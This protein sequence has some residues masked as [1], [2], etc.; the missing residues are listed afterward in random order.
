MKDFCIYLKILKKMSQN[1]TWEIPWWCLDLS[2]PVLLFELNEEKG[3]RE[4]EDKTY[5]L[6]WF[7]PRT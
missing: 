2:F 5:Q 1:F 6:S 7:K 3:R 4:T